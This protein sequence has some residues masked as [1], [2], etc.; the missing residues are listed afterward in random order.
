MSGAS[1]PQWLGLLQ[2]SLRYQDGTHSSEYRQL[3]AEDRAFLDRVMQEGVK[4]EAKRITDI[5]VDIKDKLDR[6]AVGDIEIDVLEELFDM[7]EQIDNAQ[8]FVKFGG[9]KLLLLLL[10]ARDPHTSAA[11][12]DK[13]NV[14][15]LSLLGSV[16]QNNLVVQEE[17]LRRNVLRILHDVCNGSGAT[18]AIQ[19]KCIYAISCIIRSHVIGEA[20]FV[21]EYMRDLF[22]HV[23]SNPT[24]TDDVTKRVLFLAQALT[25][26]DGT[27]VQRIN[28]IAE[29]I[30][31]KLGQYLRSSNVDISDSSIRLVEVFASSRQGLARVEPFIS[32]VLE[33]LRHNITKLNAEMSSSAT[34]DRA[35]LTSELLRIQSLVDALATDS[36]GNSNTTSVNRE[37]EIAI[38]DSFFNTSINDATSTSNSS[39]STAAPLLLGP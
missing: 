12:I 18:P 29:C 3:S 26:S 6:H 14:L 20:L 39:S 4:D 1:Q 15:A 32:D 21:T 17:A 31:S 8:V 38:P 23:L 34:E 9:I 10:H 37:V 22:T 33:G 28:L 16:A 36:D 27:S 7:T 30:F 35:H 5:I 19:S 11:H 13:V 25:S 2:W 24:T